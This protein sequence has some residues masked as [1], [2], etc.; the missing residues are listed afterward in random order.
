MPEAAAL[1]TVERYELPLLR[2]VLVVLVGLL[3]EGVA[4]SP[5][6][7]AQAKGLGEYLRA[8][9]ADVPTALLDHEQPAEETG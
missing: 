1:E 5:R 2:A 4:S 3:G 6:L 8:K 7:D 9:Q